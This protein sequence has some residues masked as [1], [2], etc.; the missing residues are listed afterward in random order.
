[1]IKKGQLLGWDDDD[2]L[3]IG[4]SRC[5]VRSNGDYKALAAQSRMGQVGG[6]ELMGCQ[7]A[8][9]QCDISYH[10]ISLIAVT[11]A[12]KVNHFVVTS[13]LVSMVCP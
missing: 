8:F 12:S 6:K 11:R 2:I 7:P 1:M 13:G 5:P 4:G 3:R 10:I 9:K